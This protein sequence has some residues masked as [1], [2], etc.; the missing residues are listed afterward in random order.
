ME[1]G[2]VRF[3]RYYACISGHRHGASCAALTAG[4]R[5][6]LVAGRRRNPRRDRA[7]AAAGADPHDRGPNRTPDRPL[8]VHSQVARAVA[9]SSSLDRQPLCARLCGGRRGSARN[10]TVRIRWPDRRPGLR[11]ACRSVAVD[12]DFRLAR[13]REPQDR[14]APHLDALQLC[15]DIR[16][17]D[18]AAA[19][20]AWHSSFSISTAIRKCPCGSPIPPGSRMSS[21]WGSIRWACVAQARRQWRGRNR[22]EATRLFRAWNCAE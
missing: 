20:S 3:G 5:Q 22:P 9:A 4:S 15:D 13:C 19:D 16:R 14:S 8:A 2:I 6:Y 10:R 12:D 11:N 1:N 21:W 17:R 18:V 7:R